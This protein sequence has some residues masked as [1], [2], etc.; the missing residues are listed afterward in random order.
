MAKDTHYPFSPPSSMTRSENNNNNI[1]IY[2][3]SVSLVLLR[4]QQVPLLLII[5]VEQLKL[6]RVKLLLLRVH[7][8]EFVAHSE[9]VK[10]HFC[11]RLYPHPSEL[12][13]HF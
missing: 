8:L 2:F 6:S 10:N 13:K 4:R 5:I 9:R 1:I 7:S 11:Q 12:I 3:V